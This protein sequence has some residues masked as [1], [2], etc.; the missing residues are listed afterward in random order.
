M[1]SHFP[2]MQKKMRRL[3]AAAPM[4]D[5]TPDDDDERGRLPP[6][7]VP[8]R[9]TVE[10]DWGYE[11]WSSGQEDADYGPA[12]EHIYGEEIGVPLGD[13]TVR[14]HEQGDT[15][16]HQKLAPIGTTRLDI[17]ALR[18]LDTDGELDGVIDMITDT[19]VFREAL[20]PGREGAFAREKRKVSR[21]MLQH[22]G[23][24]EDYGVLVQEESTLIHPAY[25]VAKK[26]G[27]LRFIVDARTL[28][29]AMKPPPDMRLNSITRVAQRL[30][31][32]DWVVLA[33]ARSWFYQFP[34][35]EDI[36]KFFGVRIGDKRNDFVD[37][38]LQV[39]CM[40]WS[41]SLAI[42]HRSLAEM[43]AGDVTPRRAF[44]I[45]GSV[46]WQSYVTRSPLCFAPAMLSY[47]RRIARTTLEDKGK[48]DLKAVAPPS[49]RHEL[50]LRM[51][52]LEQNSWLTCVPHT[53]GASVWSD[54][55]STAWAAIAIEGT[56]ERVSQGVFSEQER[57]AHI[58]LKE[59]YAA[60][61]GLRLIIASGCTVRCYID[62]LPLVHCLVKGHCSNFRGNILLQ[63]IVNTAT[64]KNLTLD[65]VWVPTTE[66][67]AD[68]YT[69]GVVHPAQISLDVTPLD[70]MQP[71]RPLSSTTAPLGRG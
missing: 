26:S 13:T 10:G 6:P 54:A 17:D 65:A 34:V 4:Y 24:L 35:A 46:V 57:G 51:S 5:A 30:A 31:N 59:A 28:N 67:R 53:R 2:P 36:Q 22:L 21:H 1:A 20:L 42:A 16:Q 8:Q 68:C 38:R 56:S 69:R 63:H 25:T 39:L 40:G 15:G 58:F 44:K 32:A 60:L 64:A 33:D 37:A 50:R 19:A 3:L 47:I 18:Q 52:F 55:S 43:I 62:N 49:V 7:R 45:F 71:T 23:Q 48:W 70:Q 29:K 66:Q 61:Q 9:K 11:N 27:G 14:P 12:V 41:Y